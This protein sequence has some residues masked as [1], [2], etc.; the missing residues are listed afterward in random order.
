M[1]IFDGGTEH[2]TPNLKFGN[3]SM[4]IRQRS[5][6][7]VLAGVLISIYP[8]ATAKELKMESQQPYIFCVENYGAIYVNPFL[9]NPS[10]ELQQAPK[11]MELLQP[12]DVLLWA[13]KKSQIGEHTVR[14]LYATK[15][16]MA[17]EKKFSIRVRSVERV[18][19]VFGHPDDE[20][21]IVAK[22]K[23]LADRGVDVWA[24]WTCG[25]SNLRN[26][27]SRQAL[28]KVGLKEDRLIF[29]NYGNL[30]TAKGLQQKVAPLVK[31][32]KRLPFDQIYTNAF[33]G[34]HGQHDMS[35][36]VT[37]QA[38]RQANF[39]GQIYEHPLYNMSG[40]KPN[41]FT[42]VPATMPKV[43]MK[44]SQ[45]ELDFILSLIPCYKS[46]KQVTSGFMVGLTH[47]QK[48]HPHYRPR[49]N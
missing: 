26:T 6:I 21:G 4:M 49:P 31:L 13:P 24:V 2:A 8:F 12:G 48:T 14:V 43:E 36:F 28:A 22:M 11:G 35:H 23:R 34:G 16:S 7:F 39:H 3:H 32:L 47:E 33:E 10:M 15:T 40:G 38:A 9:R 45:A 27:E 42:L 20:F 5:C 19:C 25:G 29:Q 46:Q 1:N 18:L 17:M 44:L 37:V 41:L 30:N